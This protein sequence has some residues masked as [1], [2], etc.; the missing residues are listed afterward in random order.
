MGFRKSAGI[1]IFRKKNNKIYYL[2]LDYGHNYWGFTKGHI[3][4]GEEIKETAL[5]EA[6]EETGLNDVEIKEG[7]KEWNKYFFKMNNENIFKVVT[8]FLGETEE[9]EVTISQEHKGYQWLEYQ[10]ALKQLTFKNS[11]RMLEKA[12]NFIKNLDNEGESV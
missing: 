4:P 8:Y 10:P 1:I 3:E 2:V 9:E 12:N 7:F 11:R 5:R 6:E